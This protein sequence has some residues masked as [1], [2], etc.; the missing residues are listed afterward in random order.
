M[1]RLFSV[2]DHRGLL[3]PIN[4]APYGSD[5]SDVAWDDMQGDVAQGAGAA[6]LTLGTAAANVGL[7]SV[8]VHIQKEKVGTKDEIP[9]FPG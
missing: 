1:S 3:A 5:S 6:V 4:D 9:I 8:D 2:S 7:L